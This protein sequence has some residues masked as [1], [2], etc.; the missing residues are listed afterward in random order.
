MGCIPDEPQEALS[1][2]VLLGLELVADEV[3]DVFGVGGGSEL[4]VADFLLSC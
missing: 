2:D 1:G 4:T 3:L